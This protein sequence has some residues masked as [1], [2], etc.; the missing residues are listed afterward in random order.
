MEGTS[1]KGHPGW[2]FKAVYQ[3]PGEASLAMLGHLI[4]S[5]FVQLL[6]QI[7]HSTAELHL[8][9]QVLAS[10]RFGLELLLC[11]FILGQEYI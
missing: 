7:S 6:P 9:E 8:K 3:L 2:N 11:L 10:D 5:T 1:Q 4:S